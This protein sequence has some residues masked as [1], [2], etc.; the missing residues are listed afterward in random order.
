[1]EYLNHGPLGLLV[2]SRVM[3]AF[4]IEQEDVQNLCE[5]ANP[6]KVKRRNQDIAMRSRVHV[7]CF[8]SL[9][10]FLVSICK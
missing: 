10:L 5:V 3:E 2:Q 6:V 7:S 9:N 4:R 8:I 1:M